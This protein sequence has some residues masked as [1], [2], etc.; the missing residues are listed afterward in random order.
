MGRARGPPHAPPGGSAIAIIGL[1]YFCITRAGVKKLSELDFPA[2][3]TSGPCPGRAKPSVP[4]LSESRARTSGDHRR[5]WT[6][7]PCRRQRRDTDNNT[8]N[9]G[10]TDNG[11][12]EGGGS[13]GGEDG[14]GGTCYVM[15][16]VYWATAERREP[17]GAQVRVRP[18]RPLA[19]GVPRGALP[20]SAFAS[21]RQETVPFQ[22]ARGDG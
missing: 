7:P 20:T 10:S 6:P 5:A 4:I 18:G 16:G 1:D 22:S 9:D 11:N 2:T 21:N 3:T 19:G 8:D 12:K 13:G 15:E 14:S 17:Q